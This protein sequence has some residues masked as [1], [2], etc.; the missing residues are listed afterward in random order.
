M[1][2]DLKILMKEKFFMQKNLIKHGFTFIEILMSILIISITFIGLFYIISFYNS[3]IT[4]NKHEIKNEIIISQAYEIFN[5][6]PLEFK[7]N[8]DLL[9][10]GYWEN[11]I[12]YIM[13]SN[14]LKFDIEN[15]SYY[16]LVKVFYDDLLIEQWYREFWI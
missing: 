13:D 10:E 7:N 3:S 15:H 1:P 6:D 9:Y 16:V 2:H 14:N 11:N 5:C 12:I 4:K 8:I